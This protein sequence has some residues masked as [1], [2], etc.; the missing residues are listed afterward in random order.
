MAATFGAQR[1]SIGTSGETQ[2]TTYLEDQGY[3]I[4]KTN[5]RA[6]RNEVDI[7][8]EKNGLIV[9]VEVKARTSYKFGQPV[10]AVGS[11]KTTKIIKVAKHYLGSRGLSGKCKVRFDVI[12]IHNGKIEHIEDAF[13]KW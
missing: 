4:L 1:R 13:R 5:Y 10:E 2:A 12:G 3:V 11:E 8:C 6:H 9:F 7:I